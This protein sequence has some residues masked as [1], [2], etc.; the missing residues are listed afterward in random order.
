[1]HVTTEESKALNTLTGPAI[2]ISSSGMASGGRILHHLHNHIPDPSAT[3][4]FVGYQGAGTLGNLMVHG[5]QSVRIF[6]DTL[7]VARRRQPERLQR[8]RRSKR[9]AALARTLE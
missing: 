1:M 4:V 9:T 3:I 7:E 5:A 8:A 2:I 6:G